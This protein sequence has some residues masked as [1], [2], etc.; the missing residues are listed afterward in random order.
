MIA[1]FILAFA[2]LYWQRIVGQ[3]V[4][5]GQ[6]TIV[7]V[8]RHVPA[9]GE[10]IS[11]SMPA[12]SR[13]AQIPQEKG[14]IRAIPAEEATP[15]SGAD[16][17]PLPVIFSIGTKPAVINDDEGPSRREMQP[18]GILLN[19]SD[20]RIQFA[21]DG[22]DT[23]PAGAATEWRNAFRQRL[24]TEDGFRRSTDSSR[25]RLSGT[26]QSDTL[27]QLNNTRESASTAPRS[28]YACFSESSSR[29]RIRVRYAASSASVTAMST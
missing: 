23:G 25:S 18:D 27:I 29:R 10:K 24:G 1:S 14:R 28:A 20:K 13:N 8:A 5:E 26:Y 3:R 7:A 16:D 11:Q 9:R 12:I 21:H 2:Y 4:P 17:A 19:S 15:P 22:D 6:S